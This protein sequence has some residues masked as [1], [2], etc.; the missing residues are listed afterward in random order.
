[1]DRILK[2]RIA[3]L[4]ACCG[5]LGS[6]LAVADT[7]APGAPQQVNARQL[8]VADAILEYCKKA[9]PSSNE[10]WEFE[11]SR[12][13]QG[14]SAETLGQVRNSAAYLQAHAAEAN[15]AAQIEPVNA[16][17]VC[18]KSLAKRKPADT[19]KAADGSTH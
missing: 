15:F 13:T 1:M 14:A 8:G 3:L 2:R 16:K 4:V 17:H 7:Q 10:K 19:S 9:Y 5:C 6:A 11:V 18:A 12:L